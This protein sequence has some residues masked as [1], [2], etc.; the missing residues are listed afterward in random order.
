VVVHDG[1]VMAAGARI[2][3]IVRGQAAHAA[4]PHLA[5]DPL[6]AAASL[7]VGVQSLVSRNL[8]PLDSGVVSLC[9]MEAGHAAN[10]I[11]DHA[12]MRGTMRAH[13]A[14]VMD[15]Q[16]D[17]LRRIAD[18][19]ARA[20]GVS[21]AVDVS[22]GPIVT[23]NT[24]EEAR[25]AAEAVAGAGLDLRRDM[26]PSMAGEDFS[27]FLQERPGAFMWIGN[28]SAEGGRDLHS[29]HY[30]FNDAILPAAATSLAAVA[31]KALSA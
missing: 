26:P 8:D 30:D 16:E 21:I 18:G 28:G 29:P 3:I 1:P 17:G 31:R 4:M 11:P 6:L 25:L 19:V 27:W 15:L 14:A 12:I 2:E 5:R 24:P 7:L 20:H 9:T 23:A 13:R 22:R 10:Q